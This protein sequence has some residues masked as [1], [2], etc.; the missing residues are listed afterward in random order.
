MTITFNNTDSA[1]RSHTIKI[2]ATGEVN[3][4]YREYNIDCSIWNGF[5]GASTSSLVISP[6]Q[7]K[8]VI[9]GTSEGLFDK[10]REAGKNN[11]IYINAVVVNKNTKSE[12]TISSIR[13][14]IN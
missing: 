3:G 10:F 9:F 8:E 12:N 14:M 5:D 11:L 7:T 1:V 4:E 2:K 6:S 13:I